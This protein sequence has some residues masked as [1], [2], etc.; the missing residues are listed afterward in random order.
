MADD[1]PFLA[2]YAK[3]GRAGC[4]SCK[5]NI[6]QGSLRLAKML[7]SPHFDGKVPNWFHY[8]CFFGKAKVKSV[9][10]IDKFDSL[11]WEDQERIK[12][13]LAAGGGGGGGKKGGKDGV[14][15]VK[16][17]KDSDFQV[18]YA[19]S[20]RAKCK[21]CEEK[22]EKGV[23]R[24]A[25]MVEPEGKKAF[26]GK[27]PQ[28]YHVDCFAEMKEELEAVDLPLQD[29]DGFSS[30][31]EEDLKTLKEKVGLT[32]EKKVKPR[33]KVE[34]KPPVPKTKEESKEEKQLK[35]Q[36]QKFWKI[37]DD[38]YSNV[39]MKLLKL[40]CEANEQDNTGGDSNILDRCA[41]GLLFGALEACPECKQIRLTYRKEGYVCTGDMSAWTKCI[42]T[43]LDP[44]RRPWKIPAELKEC[45]TFL[46]QYTPKVR[47][48]IFPANVV[49][50]P[51]V[52]RTE[53]ESGPPLST[54]SVAFVGRSKTS[55]GELSAKVKALGGE[56][57]DKPAQGVFCVISS[58]AEVM[59]MGSRMQQAERLCIPVVTEE[60]LDAIKKGGAQTMLTQYAIAAWG[61]KPSVKEE[62]DTVDGGNKSVGKK[63]KLESNGEVSSKKAKMTLKGGAVVDPES[64]LED[65]CHVLSKKGEIYNVVLGLV[66]LL[67][68]TNSYYKLQLLQ[69]DQ[70]AN[71]IFLFRAW[72]RVGTTIGG[73]K[74][75][76]YSTV[77]EALEDFKALY[78]EKTGNEWADRKN[79]AKQPNKF[80]PLDIDYG[81]DDE[82]LQ[83]KIVPGSISKLSTP[84]QDI[85][86]MIFDI[87]AMK[88]ALVEFE[89]DL[90]KMPLGKLSKKQIESAYSVLS[91]C[92]KLVSSGENA[93]SKIL[94]AS[95]RFFTL[96]PHDFGM[97]KPPL[98]N[99]ADLIKLKV[100]M[101]DN[102][103]EIEVAYSLLK[104]SRGDGERDPIDI[105]YES[106]KADIN[107]ISKDSEEFNMIQE[108]VK[109]THAKTHRHY[110]LK[111]EEVFSLAREG[112]A[113]RYRPF[114][115]LPNRKL[116]WHG[117]RTTNYAGIL[118]QG[119]RI[120]PPEAP[121]TGYMFGKGVYFADMVSKSANY[122]H[123]H[124][125][126]NT[127]LML[128]CEVALGN[129]YELTAA[130][131]ITKLPGGKQSCKGLGRTAPDP[132]QDLTLKDGT[133][134]PLGNG[135][136]S[137]AKD[138]SL[139]YN[140]FIVYDTAQINMKYL[141]RLKFVK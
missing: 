115:E 8:S 57:V 70:K 51:K 71:K 100:D 66:D 54:K 18:E 76:R 98:L 3:S 113:K 40:M 90:K 63:R 80:Y 29:V 75:Q 92:Q 119:L 130:K 74:L 139:L 1:Y 106:L 105:H 67:R 16:K 117:S 116:L 110:S 107:V 109:N 14:D 25:K 85:I 27:L 32:D 84:V 104:G 81:Q 5:T 126:N 10:E 135:V 108:Y 134:V 103:L 43:T 112:E 88:N 21:N 97:K 41:D 4:K 7:Q 128:L 39:E 73:N 86:K 122:C 37:R 2:E 60:Y 47:K 94:D 96:I 44:K 137:G 91:E 13:K 132:S 38:L 33:K 79:F 64:G 53:T 42:Y 26:L 24:I 68:G 17:D 30:L 50:K 95:N 34:E 35:T 52:E 82:E 6:A 120:A 125:S 56:V 55:K 77:S 83:S 101:L 124:L 61:G 89:I 133:I 118:S 93:A 102:L 129:M 48:R 65:K 11:R 62:K 12:E 121:V 15:G 46:S 138:T 99:D 31:S 36:N 72:G 111:V 9:E 58:P 87:E 140:E 20:S 141:V 22:I 19:K 114:K 127:G 45:S 59:K 136:E 78:A 69:H 131:T 49:T 123:S 28:W 23:I